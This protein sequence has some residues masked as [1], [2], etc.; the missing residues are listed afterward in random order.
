MVKTKNSND[1]L[2][3]DRIVFILKNLSESD[4]VQFLSELIRLSLSG[5]SQEILDCIL[6]WEETAE[7][8]SIPEKREKILTRYKSLNRKL[9][10]KCNV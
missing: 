7:I 1:N 9:S 5:N 4:K 8:N 10:K 3:E 6:D 2:V